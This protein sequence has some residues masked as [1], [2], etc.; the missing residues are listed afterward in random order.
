MKPSGL[1]NDLRHRADIFIE[2]EKATAGEIGKGLF[3]V[4]GGRL[5]KGKDYKVTK[6]KDGYVISVN[7]EEKEGFKISG[8]GRFYVVSKGRMTL[9]EN[10]IY[11]NQ[12]FKDVCSVI[13][14]SN[15]RNAKANLTGVEGLTDELHSDLVKRLTDRGICTADKAE[16]IARDFLGRNYFE[17]GKILPDGN[18]SRY[19]EYNAGNY[20]D[21][22]RGNSGVAQLLQGFV[23]E[24]EMKFI[25]SNHP[26]MQNL[27]GLF[28]E[29]GI[30]S[31]LPPAVVGG[32]RRPVPNNRA[33][34]CYQRADAQGYMPAQHN[35]V[36][37]TNLVPDNANPFPRAAAVARLAAL[38]PLV[39]RAYLP[40]ILDSAKVSIDISRAANPGI[41]DDQ[42]VRTD[43]NTCHAIMTERLAWLK[44]RGKNGFNVTDDDGNKTFYRVSFND[45][46]KSFSISEVGKDELSSEVIKISSIGT[47][48][49]KISAVN[50]GEEIEITRMDA[51]ERI[52]VIDKL[53]G[54]AGQ[55]G[56]GAEQR[57]EAESLA[58]IQGIVPNP[59]AVNRMRGAANVLGAAAARI[60]GR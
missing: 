23:L 37:I 18:G 8:N 39:D 4:G 35:L 29:K 15:A 31:T 56:I 40:A 34:E 38:S 17:K 26:H 58:N 44:A 50:N 54:I 51:A 22:A 41:T 59:V 30:L 6:V 42:L 25:N 33:Q 45:R 11:N 47:N 27:L 55:Q 16:E 57:K 14:E 19:P 2:M 49:H 20:Y 46:D 10:G 1:V 5:T 3:N 53:S 36:K 48:P 12:D 43:L 9:Q 21:I 24:N 32:V 28:Y 52:R 7:G 13:K 60:T